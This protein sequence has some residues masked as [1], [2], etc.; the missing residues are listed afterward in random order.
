MRA[1][2]A[3][4]G[5]RPKAIVVISGHW[6]EKDFTVTSAP[7]PPLLYDYYGFPEHTYRL[8]YPAPGSQALAQ[9]IQDLLSDAGLDSRADAQR[10]FDHGVFIPFLLIYPD[11]SIPVVQLSLRSSL[12]PAVHLR[13]GLALTSLRSQGVLIVGSGMSYHNLRGFGSRPVAASDEF[14]NWLTQTVTDPDSARRNQLLTGW[15]HAPSARLAHPREEHL[16]PLMV[17]AGAAG[18]DPGSRILSDRVMAATISAYQFG[19]R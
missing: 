5:A 16:I 12:D 11:A 7:H 14:D 3:N 18:S 8:Q 15:S 1:L 10:G 9:Q 4:V 6:E 19:N 2:A 13:A 17:A